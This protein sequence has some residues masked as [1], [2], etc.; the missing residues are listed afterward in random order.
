MFYVITMLIKKKIPIKYT[1]RNENEIKTY[2][3]K[4]KG[5]GREDKQKKA[6]RQTENNK[7]A[8]VFPYQ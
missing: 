1:Q 2:H 4:K 6:T 8:I 3:Y 7:M 5:K